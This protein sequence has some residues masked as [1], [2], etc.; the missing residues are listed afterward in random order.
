MNY[1]KME[2]PIGTG[3]NLLI[4]SVEFQHNGFYYCYGEDDSHTPF[5]A[6]AQL[7]VYGNKTNSLLNLV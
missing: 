6:V 2:E 3:T 5:T 1:E 4:K 7:K